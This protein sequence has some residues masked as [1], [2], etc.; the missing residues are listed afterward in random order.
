ML[1][2][3]IIFIIIIFGLISAL[4]FLIVADVADE[5]EGYNVSDMVDEDLESNYN[6]LTEIESNITTM[7][8]ETSSKGGMSVISTYTTM[9]S[10]TFTVIGIVFGSVRIF[11]N[12]L[13]SFA[14][15]FGIPA[16]VVNLFM[17]AILLIIITLLVFGVVSSVSRGRL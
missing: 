5:N 13:V 10:S 11:R 17:G 14:G 2:R 8:S 6:T 1:P 15:D 9:F 16:A 12:S 7:Q 4:G 3:D